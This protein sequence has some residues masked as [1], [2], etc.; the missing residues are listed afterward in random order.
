MNVGCLLDSASRNAGGLFE[1]V[2]RLAQSLHERN[3]SVRVFSLDDE[4]TPVD[5]E[6]WKPIVV[7][8]LPR[9]F[10]VWG[11]SHKLK[12]ELCESDL[13][14]LL[15]HGL[16]KYSSVASSAW[17]RRTKRPYIVH[18]HGML[19][20]WAVNNSK[21]KKRVAALLYENEH[22]RRAACIRALCDSE[23]ESIRAYGLRNPICIIPNGIDLPALAGMSNDEG[24]TMNA[25]GRK[26]L[27][28][29]GRLHPKKNLGPL[30]H[31]WA[32]VQRDSKAAQEWVLAIVGWDQNGY[33]TELRRLAIDLRLCSSLSASTGERAGVRCSTSFPL[34]ETFGASPKAAGESPALPSSS[35]SVFFLGSK[36]GEEKAAAYRSA[37]AFILPSLSEGLPMVVLEAWAYA[38]PV[39]MTEECNL[40][41]GFQ[42]NAALRIGTDS[43]AIT[44]GLRELFQMST[45]AR[46]AI[47]ARGLELVKEKFLWTEIGREMHRVC[48]WVVNG[49]SPP[50]SVRF[51]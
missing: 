47:G 25:N 49:G 31:A 5:V 7:R 8:T 3:G 36:F 23:A 48:D 30:L 17:H 46:E 38:R 21:W 29:L 10:G 2:R 43:A 42:A 4:H 16:W 44:K 26:V 20:P 35:D 40:P 12:A 41:E 28:Y 27:L 50:S 45:S 33:E 9:H 32:D 6:A 14:V 37:S 15:T 34:R 11:Y 39:L 51:D 22:L 13:D 1:S 24:Q 19:D 18:P